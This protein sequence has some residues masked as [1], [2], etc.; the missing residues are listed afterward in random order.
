V[1]GTTAKG[2]RDEGGLPTIVY[3][4]RARAHAH[5]AIP[6]QGLIPDNDNN[7]AEAKKAIRKLSKVVPTKGVTMTC[8]TVNMVTVMIDASDTNT[9]HRKDTVI[10]SG[11]RKGNIAGEVL[12]VLRKEAARRQ[13]SFVL[14]IPHHQAARQ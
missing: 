9:P 6:L 12:V 7:L 5:A 13:G 11:E 10:V 8:V 3:L 2:E 4:G 14:F 1:T